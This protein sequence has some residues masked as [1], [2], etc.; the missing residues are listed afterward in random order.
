VAPPVYRWLV[1]RGC[2]DKGLPAA[3]YLGRGLRVDAWR[4]GRGSSGRPL[5]RENGSRSSAELPC[6]SPSRSTAD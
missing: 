2:Q 5:P 3:F 1:G 4:R 6:R